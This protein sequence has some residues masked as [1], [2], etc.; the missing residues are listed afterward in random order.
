MEKRVLFLQPGRLVCYCSHDS[1]GHNRGI[2][3]TDCADYGYVVDKEW[4]II[5]DKLPARFRHYLQNNL[6]SQYS[7]VFDLPE[8]ECHQA[9]LKVTTYRDRRHVVERL[10]RKRFENSLFSKASIAGSAS[11]RFLLMFGVDRNELCQSLLTEIESVGVSLRSIHSS[12]LLTPEIVKSVPAHNNDLLVVIPLH[13]CFRLVACSGTSVLFTRQVTASARLDINSSIDHYHTLNHSLEETLVYVQRQHALWKPSIVF[14]G[15]E[16]VAE[17]LKSLR[18]SLPV[19]SQ[20]A[21]ISSYYSSRNPVIRNTTV[22]A[23]LI[24]A[25]AQAGRGYAQKA[26]RIVYVGRRV[27]SICAA[28]ALCGL[29]GAATSTAVANKLNN[30]HEVVS[31]SYRQ[32]NTVL[33]DDI[34]RLESSYEQPVE[35]VRQALV[36]ARLLELSSQEPLEFLQELALNVNRQSDIS[37]SSV[38]WEADDII[39]ETLLVTLQEPPETLES[40][41][42]EQI[43]RVSLTGVV[44]GTPE[45]VFDQFES[46]VSVLRDATNNPSVVVV[47]APFGLGERRRTTGRD[48]RADQGKFVLEITNE[49]VE[50]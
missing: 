31:D 41:S 7:I 36:A 16:A 14:V 30:A 34:A 26:H 35:A 1:H 22:E 29:A 20:V 49:K 8:E 24:H 27:R 48:F 33:A 40:V 5:G 47:E 19:A 10:K 4:E 15:K 13:A 46:F 12:T 42:L 3:R 2:S 50:R 43:Y 23:L 11:D 39:D 17:K 44:K 32:S 21:E 18:S 28:L 37:M 38:R 25:S 6:H 9:E 45:S